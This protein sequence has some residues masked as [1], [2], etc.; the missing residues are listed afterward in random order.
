M[1]KSFL[2]IAIFVAIMISSLVHAA[3]CDLSV[4]LINQ[5]PY[6]AVP[7]DYIKLVFQITG[8]ENPEC[9]LVDFQIIPD[10]PI[11]LDPGVSPSVKINSG[12]Y[13]TSDYGSY[14]LAPFKV[15]VDKDALDGENQIKI[16]YSAAL[17]AGGTAYVVKNFN[18]SVN[19]SQGEFEV[20]VDSY[21]FATNQLTLGILNTG[22]NNVR[23]L[24]ASILEG[25]N[26]SISGGNEKIIGDLN[27]N[28]DTT[29]SFNLVPKG[30][31]LKVKL[32]YNDAA[33][34][35]RSVTQDVYFN[36][37]NY[38]ATKASGSKLSTSFYL[39]ML[40]WIILIIVLVSRYY[41]N[42]KKKRL[43]QLRKFK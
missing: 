31:N 42:K 29:V 11:S 7:E 40:T 12:T 35:R 10:F 25:E 32:S 37:D 5:D 39:L 33:G 14:A 30:N 13:S 15:R 38:S 8:V 9:G 24:T 17:Q 4:N 22:K 2:P 21:S 1:K 6:P 36:S 26:L 16:K 27:S 3:P 41:K 19:N 34:T 20:I 28:D 18:I 23:S 43:E